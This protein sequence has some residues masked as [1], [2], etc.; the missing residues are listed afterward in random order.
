MKRLGGKSQRILSGIELLQAQDN[1][2]DQS[3]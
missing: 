2:W 1:T 3:S